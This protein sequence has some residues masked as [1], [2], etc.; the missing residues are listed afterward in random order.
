MVDFTPTAVTSSETWKG[1]VQNWTVPTTATYVIELYGASGGNCQSALGGKGAYVKTI[2]NLTAGDSLRIIVPR[3]GSPGGTANSGDAAG[4]GGGAFVWKS[5]GTLLAAAGGGGGAG[6]LGTSPAGGSGVLTTSGGSAPGGVGSGQLAAG[7]SG[8]A[9]GGGN[10]S[11][12]SGIGAAAGWTQNGAP[13]GSGWGE[14]SYRPVDANFPGMGSRMGNAA[15][16]QRHGGYGGGGSGAYGAGPGGGYSGG[17]VGGYSSE[18]FPAGGGGS[19]SVGT[20]DGSSAAGSR[21]GDGLVKIYVDNDTPVPT[22]LAPNNY[23][24]IGLVTSSTSVSWTYSDEESNPQY[25]YEISYRE[26]GT[27][28]AYTTFTSANAVSTTSHTFA[29]NTFTD[30]KEYEWRLRLDDNEGG[31]W[32]PYYIAYFTAGVGKWIYGPAVATSSSTSVT[33]TRTFATYDFESGTQGWENNPFFGTYT[34]C[35]FT[36]STTRPKS[37]TRSLEITWPTN[38]A[39][40]QSRCVTPQIFGFEIG[41]R[42]IA[43]ADIYVP[44]GSPNVRLDTFLQDQGKGA[45]VGPIMDKD[46]WVTAWSEFRAV[47]S[48]IYFAVVVDEPTNNTQK[49]F[50]D[51]FRIEALPITE[52]GNYQLQVRTSDGVGFGP[53]STPSNT[54]AV[55]SGPVAEYISLTPQRVGSNITVNWKYRDI[56]SQAQTKYKIRYRKK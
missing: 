33:T 37:G 9:S 28:Q 31:G 56:D 54:F 38:G 3:A 18:G 15:T 1:S 52:G 23:E 10:V 39:G 48:G 50:V 40:G 44:A 30:G 7:T 12:G 21:T 51:N 14:T 34:D 24:P 45:T 4:G 35:T 13:Y 19:Y 17:A 11:S 27:T 41:K 16:G 32:S 6:Y 53:W 20:M 2:I 47:H 5:D 36:N 29:A 42:Y 8:Q 49:C 26:A 25:K 55:R 46:M 43:Y 22:N